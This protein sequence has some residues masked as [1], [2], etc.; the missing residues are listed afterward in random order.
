MT[1]DRSNLE[2][3]IERTV[4]RRMNALDYRLIAENSL[5]Q[6]EYDQAVKAL[7]AWAKA[8]YAKAKAEHQPAKRYQAKDDTGLLMR[9]AA[10]PY[11]TVDTWTKKIKGRYRELSKAQARARLLN[12]RNGG[13]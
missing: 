4:E 9:D 10:R 11:V 1:E 13:K 7:D 6:A 8:E 3:R 2:D 5:T 12:S